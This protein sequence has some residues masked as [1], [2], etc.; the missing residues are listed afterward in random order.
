MNNP[1]ILASTKKYPHNPETMITKCP[2]CQHLF[3]AE[4]H[5]PL[6]EGIR[7]CAYIMQAGEY[8]VKPRAES[9]ADDIRRRYKSQQVYTHV[10]VYSPTEQGEALLYRVKL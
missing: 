9:F 6:Q 2:K 8:I 7:V 3:T 1:Y 4:T 5:T 10:D